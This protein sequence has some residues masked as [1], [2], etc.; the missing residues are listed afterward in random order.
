M[1]LQRKKITVRSKRGKTYQRS[2]MVKAAQPAKGPA[3]TRKAQGAA[4]DF[5][6]K[7]WKTMAL[8]GAA[9]GVGISAG[10][11]AGH[12]I[13]NKMGLGWDIGKAH[14]AGM[15][16]GGLATTAAFRQSKR[17]KSLRADYDRMGTIDK[18]KVEG[19]SRLIGVP[20]GLATAWTTHH[21]LRHATRG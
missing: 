20:A 4:T 1:A 3:S 2:V 9:L 8:H 16:A 14:T 21:V 15:M 10:Q 17:W 7:H 6:K 19:V 13:G 5:T 12:H 11:H 18:L